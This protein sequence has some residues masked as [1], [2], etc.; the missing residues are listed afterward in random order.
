MS[1]IL[2]LTVAVAVPA[3]WSVIPQA[4]GQGGKT[5]ETQSSAAK[6]SPGES[7]EAIVAERGTVRLDQEAEL[8]T[9]QPGTLE[10]IGATEG[11]RV[12]KGQVVAQLESDVAEAALAVAAKTAESDIDIR[13]A[14]AAADVAQMDLE[15]SLRANEIY[16]DTV[17][18]LEIE[19]LRLAVTRARLQ[20][21]KAKLDQEIAEL[22]RD[23]RAAELAS[24]TIRSPL[25]GIVIEVF[26][27]P[28][29]AVQQGDPILHVVRTDVVRV[30]GFVSVMEAARVRPG[31]SVQARIDLE[32]LTGLPK[33]VVEKTLP[34]LAEMTFDGKV[35]FIDPTVDIVTGDI[36]V[37]A[38]V[39]NPGNLL[40][41]G[42]PATMTIHPTGQVPSVAS[43]E[44]NR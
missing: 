13:Y 31:D 7:A 21:D 1:R 25:E 30:E 10:S 39:E 6:T 43:E 22:T 42:L 18:E 40:K 9:D 2:I 17:A 4:H 41:A 5:P 28:G 14:K 37:W 24:H 34:E 26:K 20:A 11:E 33:E 44:A 15:K 23:Q 38:R 32:R 29:E 12:E 35:M 27:H 3:V 16:S 8:A 19:R 36:R